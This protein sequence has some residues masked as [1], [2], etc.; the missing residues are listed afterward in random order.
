MAS[1]LL[2]TLALQLSDPLL[3]PGVSVIVIIVLI[4]GKT[5]KLVVD[6]GLL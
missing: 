1:F 4:G 2:G 5:H 6:D 3:H